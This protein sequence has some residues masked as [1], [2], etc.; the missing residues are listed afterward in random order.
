[1]H[2]DSTQ[3]FYTKKGWNI[4]DNG[5]FVDA[6]LYEDLRSYCKSYL[7]SNR[8]RL[9]KYFPQ[10]GKF[11]LD[12]ASGPIQYD[13]YLD[14]SSHYLKR[15]CVDLSE[16]ALNIAKSRA[17]NHIETICGNLLELNFNDLSFDAILS[18]HTIY[19][20][21]LKDQIKAINSLLS[22]LSPSGVCLIIYSNPCCFIEKLK[23]LIKRVFRRKRSPEFTFERLT[24]PE[25]QE[26]FPQAEIIPYRLLSGEDMKRLFP[27]SY[28][29][30][31]LLKI[32]L[33]L[34]PYLPLFL[35][36]YYIIRFTN[37]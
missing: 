31:L 15:F 3:F 4:D 35:V 14:Y 34:E 12:C 27:N 19:H 2:N 22:N 7:S 33:L 8:Q 1:M 24:I 26:K 32:I 36:Q 5:N 18:I 29:S 11:L 28:L 13:E 37:D 6:V 23:G 9:S 20:I 21:K 30:E 25:I 16:D 10:H 17:P